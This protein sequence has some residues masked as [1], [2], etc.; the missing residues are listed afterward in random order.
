MAA[1][2]QLGSFSNVKNLSL[3]MAH[4]SGKAL[5]SKELVILRTLKNAT[6]KYDENFNINIK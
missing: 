1:L 3:K 4:A 6:K 2:V 5:L